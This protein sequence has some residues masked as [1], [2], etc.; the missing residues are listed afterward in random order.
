M[1]TYRIY[2]N[3]KDTND[4]ELPEYEFETDSEIIEKVRE[5]RKS[6]TEYM[7]KR[8]YKYKK[9]DVKSGEITD[10][11]E[12]DDKETVIDKIIYIWYNI[13]NF[14]MD[15]WYELKYAYER[16]VN[17]YDSRTW[18]NIDISLLDMVEKN[19]L[20]LM[21]K[22]HG[23][24]N[25]YLNKAMKI[26]NPELTD[27]EINNTYSHDNVQ[28][29]LANSLWK[30]DL[31]KL[32]IMCRLKKYYDNLGIMEDYSGYEDKKIF[33]IPYKEF[34][35]EIDFDELDRLSEDNYNA[36]MDFIKQHLR[37]MWD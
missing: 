6:G 14:I 3:G 35:K 34:S 9:M 37:E 33:K 16:V 25:A 15:I 26:L 22:S 11:T 8:V 1:N 27:E 17:K 23:C 31:N 20:I 13:W 21:E 29:D 36:L 24:P 2:I 7:W 32:V 18:W 10:I 30:N 12:N 5:L 19:T 4:I 28:Y